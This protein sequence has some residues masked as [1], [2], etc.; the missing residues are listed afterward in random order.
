LDV[1]AGAVR[2]AG[3]EVPQVVQPDRWQLGADG[4]PVA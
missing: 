2:E 3:R 4:V 1:G